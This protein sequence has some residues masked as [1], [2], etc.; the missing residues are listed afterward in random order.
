[1]LDDAT[2]ASVPSKIAADDVYTMGEAARLKGVSYHTVSRAVR[3][4]S[5]ASRRL[6]KMVF[7]SLSDLEAWRPMVE[8]APHKFRRRTPAS[9]AAPALIDLASGERVELARWLAALLEALDDLTRDRPAGD[10]LDSLCDRLAAALDFRRVALWRFDQVAGVAVRLAAVGPA[11]SDLPDAV[12]L[13]MIPELTGLLGR[14]E[15][16]VLDVPTYGDRMPAALRH[17][18]TLCVVPLCSGDQMVGMLFGD[19]GG[20]PFALRP[21]DLAVARGIANLAALTVDRTAPATGGAGSG[22]K[23]QPAVVA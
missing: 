5:L 15:A 7:I 11:L 8:R 9:D 12:P 21:Q 3:R 6:G 18:T 19:R 22:P 23:R 1:M 14:R 10:V 13:A 4:G 16:T 20:R 17:L 2:T